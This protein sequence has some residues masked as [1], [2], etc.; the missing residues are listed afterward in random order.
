MG[1]KKRFESKK[2]AYSKNRKDCQGI[3]GEKARRTK[4]K[5]VT[6]LLMNGVREENPLGEIVLADPASLIA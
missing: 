6:T 4:K 2:L 1:G 5:N 3:E